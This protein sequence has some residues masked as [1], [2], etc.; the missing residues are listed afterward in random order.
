MSKVITVKNV[1]KHFKL[2]S[3]KRTIFDLIFRRES[4]S[5]E[6]L[7]VLDDITFEVNKGEIVG[8]IGRNGSGKSTLLK[9]IA[10]ILTPDS[11]RIITTGEIAPFLSIGTGFNDELTAKENV[12]LY[13]VI[14]GKTKKIM[15]AKLKQILEFAEL[16]RFENTKLKHFSSGMYARLAFASAIQLDPNIML[17][18]EVL[19]VGDISFRKKSFDIFIKFK[20]ER[21]SILFVSHD[22]SAIRQLCNRV[23]ILEKGKII[24]DGNPN[25][26]IT[27]YE[28]LMRK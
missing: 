9:L 8:I 7:L 13:G 6:D 19:S 1:K 21:K 14:M 3:S 4:Y 25:E 5:V 26:G 10:H 12:I 24:F 27:Q 11:G 17:V 16:E 18:D 22:M 20:N 15:E 2:F 28:T 23:I